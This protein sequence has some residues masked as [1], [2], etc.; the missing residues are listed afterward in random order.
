MRRRAG[1]LIALVVTG[2]G[3]LPSASPAA[4]LTCGYMGAYPGDSATKSQLSGWMASRA[5]GLGLPGELPVMG[6]LV[7]SELVNLPPG[8]S[9]SVGYFQMRTSIWDQGQ[10]AGFPENPELQLKWF[11]DQAL[12]VNQGRTGAG[13]APYGADSSHWG[14]WAADVLRPPAQ[15]RGRYQLRLDEAGALVAAGCGP[16][17]PGGG[18]ALDKIPP[19][20]RL[21][22]MRVQDPVERGRVVVEVACPEEACVAAARARLSLR[23]AARVRTISSS[24][25]HVPKGGKAKLVLR[26][27]RKLRR[28]LRSELTRRA[29][30]RTRVSVTARDAAGNQSVA[31]RVVSL[32]H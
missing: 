12:S 27:K 1:T 6:A 17:A 10:Y 4:Q 15:Y 25:R 13:Q 32:R 3:L 9:D 22:G 29:R 28:A 5:I 14:E 21:A 23:G 30:V 20:V 24:A 18:A 16:G 26:L 8:D 19:R 7:E 11:T 2:C 31:R